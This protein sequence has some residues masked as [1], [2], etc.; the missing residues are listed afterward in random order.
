MNTKTQ[1]MELQRIAPSTTRVHISNLHQVI[2]YD[3]IKV[4][5]V[6]CDYLLEQAHTH[7]YQ[8]VVNKLMPNVITQW[9]QPSCESWMDIDPYSSLR[10]VG[11]TSS[12]ESRSLPEPAPNASNPAMRQYSLRTQ[13]KVQLGSG[14]PSRKARAHVNYADPVPDWDL[15]SPT[16]ATKK[17]TRPDPHGPS[18]N[19]ISALNKSTLH[20]K[21]CHRFPVIKLQNVEM[22][23]YTDSKD[24]TDTDATIDYAVTSSSN[25]A[26]PD[27]QSNMPVIGTVAGTSRAS[28]MPGT[29]KHD[30]TQIGTNIPVPNTKCHVFISRTVGLIKH[31]R[32]RI[33]KCTKC[34]TR[35]A[36]Q[37]EINAH[38]R[39]THEKVK[40]Y[41]CHQL[42]NT[43][44]TLAHHLYSHKIAT[45]KCRCGKV[46]RFASEL[47][48]HKLTHRRIKTEHCP[49]PKFGK[50]YHSANNLAKHVKIHSNK[51]WKCSVCDYTTKDEHLL[52]SHKRKHEQTVKYTCN[53]CAKSFVYHTQWA[54][55]KAQK[56]V[57][58]L[59]R[60]NSPEV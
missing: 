25:P 50:S 39:S 42:F 1:V 15:S 54:R 17:V 3:N 58:P 5:S 32:K 41:V 23:K 9:E 44:A 45:K 11:N 27:N 49:F 34:D 59:A 19:R 37:G 26:I 30:V 10:D 18:S 20:P 31:K 35:K 16:K 22:P 60:S 28:V 43:P 51:T 2:L 52:K 7:K 33:F 47:K 29:S 6:V 36:T 12:E 46:F 53:I 56:K 55:H 13:T 8:V 48:S 14:R 38:Y 24:D 57:T 21:V 4:N 40:C